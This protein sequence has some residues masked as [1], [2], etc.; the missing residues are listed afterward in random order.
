M[1][2]ATPFEIMTQYPEGKPAYKP[3][4]QRAEA[5]DYQRGHDPHKHNEP[6]GFGPWNIPKED[7]PILA[8]ETVKVF[9]A[10]TGV[11]NPEQQVKTAV[12]LIKTAW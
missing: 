11:R 7:I 6:R 2:R 5:V 12:E 8:K 3:A 4:P 1:S 10:N 9:N